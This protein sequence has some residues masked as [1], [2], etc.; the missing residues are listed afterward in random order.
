MFFRIDAE[1]LQ[2]FEIGLLDI[3]RGRFHN[4]LELMMLV[5]TVRVVAVSSVIRAAGRFN[6]CYVPWFRSDGAKEC[7]RVHRACALFHVIWLSQYASL[8]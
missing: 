6:V 2:G 3:V 5:Q 8:F 1:F 7:R 4:H